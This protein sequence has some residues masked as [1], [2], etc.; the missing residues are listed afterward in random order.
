MAVD[1]VR[2]GTVSSDIAELAA[3]LM[4][5]ERV[6]LQALQDRRTE[7]NQKSSA[8][9]TLKT[10]LLALQSE[11]DSLAQT[12]TLSPFATKSAT[13]SDTSVLTVS[14]AATAAS[15]TLSVTVSQLARRATHVSDLYTDTGTTISGAGTGTY[16][17]S[18]TIAGTTYDASV[19][20][21]AGDTD[22]TVLDNIA[23]AITAAVGGKA[24]AVRIQ[25]ETGKSRLSLSSADTG[26]ANKI[27]F[28]DTDGLLAR[29]GLYHATPTA[30]TATTGGY[31]YE[32]L[33]GHEL[34]AAL[35]V[36]GLTYYRDKNTVTDL[37]SGVTLDL[38]ATSPTAVTVKIQPDADAAVEQIKSFIAKYNDVLDYLAQ[39]TG[40]DTQAGTRGILSLDSTFSTLALELKRRAATIV[41][42][43]TAGDPNSL[44]A[45]GV[46]AAR[47]GKLSISDETA[48]RNTF[49]T[50]PEAVQRLFN[51]A[52]GVATTLEA[53]VD[54][55]T[56]ASGRI[57]LTQSSITTR[58]NGLNNQIRRMEDTLARKQARLEDQLARNQA[59]LIQLS[60]QQAQINAF[61]SGQF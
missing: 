45:L 55:Y 26:T 19:T 30:A 28:T 49:A 1:S 44:A 15:A 53:F 48:L 35:V 58:I 12:G 9:A 41:G 38:K 3:A 39:N 33:G 51:A 31:V 29:I 59:L 10:R 14:A 37:V 20:I 60:R 27:A 11:L 32:D 24:S 23:A 42:S 46:R 34:D 56:D 13:S 6:P 7:L 47:D 57:A 8:L 50:D 16:A 22:Q 36:D 2:Q 43:Q 5:R 17:F 61:I 40:V 4:A 18:L 54:G 52:D 21:N 25:T